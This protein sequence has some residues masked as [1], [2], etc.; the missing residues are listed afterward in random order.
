MSN[1][2]LKHKSKKKF[3][4]RK[5]E[6]FNIGMDMVECYRWLENKQE[7]IAR[8]KREGNVAL[9]ESLAEEIILSNF[10]RAVAVHTVASNKGAR[11]PGL[12]KESFRTNK[13][14]VAMMATLE[15]MVVDPKKYKATPLSRIYIP[16]KDTACY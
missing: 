7:N 8:A 10:G 6:K 2:K 1:T 13:D 3:V 16:K 12:S 4:P 5:R 11:S 15:E 14:Y 9:A